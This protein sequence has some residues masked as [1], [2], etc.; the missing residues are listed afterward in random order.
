MKVEMR[1]LLKLFCLCFI[2]SKVLYPFCMHN[3]FCRSTFHFSEKDVGF[4]FK[5][6][7]HLHSMFGIKSTTIQTTSN[8]FLAL[9][10]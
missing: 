5:S 1:M 7:E 10:N 4:G 6:Y 9:H 3:F 2:D 8:L